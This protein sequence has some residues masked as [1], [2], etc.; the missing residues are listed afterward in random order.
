M[1]GESEFLRSVR[2][3]VVA[4]AVIAVGSPNVSDADVVELSFLTDAAPEYRSVDVTEPQTRL[5]PSWTDAD[6][7]RFAVDAAGHLGRVRDLRLLWAANVVGPASD[8]RQLVDGSRI[9]EEFDRLRENAVVDARAWE[10]LL[11]AGFGLPIGSQIAAAYAG[12]AER[13]GDP[14]NATRLR[15][16]ARRH[17]GCCEHAGRERPT[18]N[19]VGRSPP[20]TVEARDDLGDA[21]PEPVGPGSGPPKRKWVRR[22][23]PVE[24]HETL[25]RQ[26]SYVSR[27]PAFLCPPPLAVTD[28]VVAANLFGV[29]ETYARDDGTRPGIS[30]DVSDGLW[31]ELEQST[32]F[33]ERMHPSRFGVITRRLS[34]RDGFIVRG[35]RP[36]G[37]YDF[38]RAAE[39]L[40][41]DERGQHSRTWAGRDDGRSPDDRRVDALCD[42]VQFDDDL[43]AVVSDV[44]LGER[45]RL[46]LSWL[47]EQLRRQG[48]LR[49]GRFLDS[50]AGS[51]PP[52][53]ELARSDFGL[54]CLIDRTLLAVDPVAREV[55]WGLRL[56]P[57]ERSDRPA[58]CRRK[59]LS[60]AG[61]YAIVADG[62][63]VIAVDLVERMRQWSRRA[64]MLLVADGAEAI[65]M[66][67]DRLQAIR[68]TSGS[69]IW[70]REVAVPEPSADAMPGAFAVVGGAHLVA[71][72]R[73]DGR[74]LFTMRLSD[75]FAPR[76]RPC[77]VLTDGDDL[78][79]WDV[80]SLAKFTWSDADRSQVDR[81]EGGS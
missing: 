72:D 1:I 71:L 31:P 23:T 50:P 63:R 14:A 18:E 20:R 30:S 67:D 69:T 68:L 25:L 59:R 33:V 66:L 79:V 34:G 48:E 22:L 62:G 35:E 47:D 45:Q 43:V 16:L 32:G 6:E 52:T 65:V 44:R 17:P 8:L 21:A 28:E 41:I 80:T 51:V 38:N 55:L 73:D 13:Q 78:F 19:E 36:D 57:I 7:S 77:R 12:V 81:T 46:Q 70:S 29:V 39:L 58:G 2:R 76:R 60:I 54:L 11:Q 26:A 75:A 40:A 49:L 5:P 9:G 53:V 27:E 4:T 64:D 10:T 24:T 61:R 15:W 74:E 37:Y 3:A 42:P 56:E